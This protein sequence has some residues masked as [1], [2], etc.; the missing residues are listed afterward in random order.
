MA[1]REEV[2]KR[3]KEEIAGASAYDLPDP[4]KYKIIS[5]GMSRELYEETHAMDMLILRSR[6]HASTAVFG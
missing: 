3:F 6:A 4:I 5:E 1:D 2:L